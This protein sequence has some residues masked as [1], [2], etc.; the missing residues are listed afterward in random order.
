MAFFQKHSKKNIRQGDIAVCEFHQL[1]ARSGDQ[2]GPGPANVANEDLPYLG[3]YQNFEVELTA[4]GGGT[5]TRQLRVW[6]GL[7]MVI[8]QGCEIDYADENDSRLCVAPIVSRPNWSNGPWDLIAKRELPGYMHLP[9]LGTDGAAELEL[10]EPGPEGA[11]VLASATLLSRAI[12]KPNRIMTLAPNALPFLQESLVRF[13]SVRGW[14]SVDGLNNLIGLRI[15]SVAETAETIPGP[16]RLA[17]VVLD[18]GGADGD[19]EVTVAWG[20]R[21]SAKPM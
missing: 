5:A 8:H 7:V 16:A 20:V 3:E 13:S 6:F 9:E 1:R 19:D 4:P 12:V 18:G 2:L 15:A 10:A 17:K 21:R 11:V 14:G